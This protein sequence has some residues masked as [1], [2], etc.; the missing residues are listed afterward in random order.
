MKTF[1]SGD[2]PAFFV[3]PTRSL[4]LFFLRFTSRGVESINTIPPAPD[5][6]CFP[7]RYIYRASKAMALSTPMSPRM[8]EIRK[9]RL[10]D[11]S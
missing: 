7:P 10:P 3:S 11:T 8:V 5:P 4:F 1:P 2:I 9:R 6:R